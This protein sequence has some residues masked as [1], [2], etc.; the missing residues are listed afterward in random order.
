AKTVTSTIIKA[1]SSQPKTN[2]TNAQKPTCRNC[3][4]GSSYGSPRRSA[5]KKTFTQKQ[6]TFTAPISSNPHVKIIGGGMAVLACALRL[7]KRGVKSNVF[8]M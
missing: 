2:S 5:L 4:R 1:T 7:D 6:F 8:D 3:R